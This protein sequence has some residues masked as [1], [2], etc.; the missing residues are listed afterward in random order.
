MPIT[1]RNRDGA[2]Y[3]CTPTRQTA[4][5]SNSGWTAVVGA[6]SCCSANRLCA[7]AAWWKLPAI[8]LAPWPVIRSEHYRAW[9][10]FRCDLV[11]EQFAILRQVFHEAVEKSGVKTTP[12]PMLG[13]FLADAPLVGLHSN[14]LWRDPQ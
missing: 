2:R 7:N 5:N 11:A 3:G 13:A 12:Q 4:S 9:L 8:I 1:G 14:E 6:A 10:R